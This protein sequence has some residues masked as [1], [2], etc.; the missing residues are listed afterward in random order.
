MHN[1]T[2]LDLDRFELERRV[3]QLPSL[4][5]YDEVQSAVID[6]VL[7]MIGL[8]AQEADAGIVMEELTKE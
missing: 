4:Y 3:K 5:C 8:M 6:D 2:P 1:S 7:H